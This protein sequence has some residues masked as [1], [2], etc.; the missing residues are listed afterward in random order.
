[1]NRVCAGFVLAALFAAAG[2]PDPPGLPY[3]AGLPAA[4]SRFAASG[5]PAASSRFAAS[6]LPAAAGRPG[7]HE[8]SA[9]TGALTGW[10]DQEIPLWEREPS[11]YLSGYERT[12]L[13]G[14]F[15]YH[16]PHPEVRTSLLTRAT[17]LPMP[18]A[19]ET[20]LVPADF[21]APEAI[22]V[23]LGGFNRGTPNHDFFFS[24]DGRPA[25]TVSTI[26]DG[27]GE[28]WEIAGA[29]GC[30]LGFRS[31]LV[32]RYDD[33]MG[34]LYLAVPRSLLTP[35][36]PLRIDVAGERAGSNDWYMTFEH[37]VAESVQL[38]AEPALV[39]D[40]GG[41]RQ[42]IRV[43]VEHLGPPA[44]AD[45]L[46]D[47]EVIGRLDLALGYNALDTSLPEV[48]EPTGARVEVRI[49]GTE[50][51]ARTVTLSPVAPRTLY[52]LHHSHVDIGYTHVQEE[53]ARLQAGHLENAI[54][55]AEASRDHPPGSRFIWN[56]E[57]LWA[58][59]E[60]LR[61]ATPEQR[62]RLSEAVRRG[63]IGLDALYANVL[64]GLCR[65]EELMQLF[66]T[67]RALGEEFGVTVD[68]AMIT[69]IPGWSWAL[70]PAMAANGVRY[71]SIGPN[72]GH[73]IGSIL[74]D[75]G[76]KP[77]WW[78]S[79]SGEDRVLVWV[80]GRGYSWFHTGLGATAIT[81]RLRPAAVLEYV[82]ELA[83]AQ[84]PFE[85]AAFRYNI[86]SDNGPPDAHLA[87]T[88]RA[89]NERF[90]TP[91]IVIA[92]TAGMLREFERRYGDELP[93]LRGDI[94][95]YWEDGAGSSARETALNRRSAERLT[96]AGA[97]AAILA[98]GLDLRAAF[99]EA[100]RHVLLY[101]EH[102]WGSWNS[103]SEP[104][105]LFTLQQWETKQSFALRADS[106]S[107]A[108][109]DRIV[110]AAGA[111]PRSTPAAA[112]DIINTSSWPRS[113]LVILDQEIRRSG[114][115]VTD[116]AGSALPSQTLA[117]GS[118]AVYL[119]DVPAF[120]SRRLLI[121]DGNP[122]RGGTVRL[123]GT[124]LENGRVRV[125]VDPVSGAVRSL[126]RTG[127]SEEYV[128]N[129]RLPGLNAYYYVAGRD[130]ASPQPAGA[131]TVTVGEEGPLLAS[132]V[133]TSPAPGCRRLRREVR[134]A[135]DADWVE[136]VD[137]LDKERVLDPEG[138]CLAFPF[139]IPS[140]EVRIDLGWGHYRPGTDQLPGAN[141]NYYSV[142]HWV[143]VSNERTGVTL[144]PM[145][146]P[147]LEI[148][149]ITTDAIAVGWLES[150]EPSS[151]LYSYVM[152]NYW[153]TNYRAYQDGPVTLCYAV[154]PHGSFDP[155]ETT[156]F[157][158]DRSQPFVVV[159]TD[160]GAARPGIG[161]R[162]EPADIVATILPPERGVDRLRLRLYN[163]TAAPLRAR[164]T[165]PGGEVKEIEV[166]AL[167]V[168]TVD[169]EQRAG[170]TGG[171]STSR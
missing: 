22:F 10:P 91:R 147:L 88:V 167:A 31:V 36:R 59:D 16:S 94:T 150:S 164:L 38:V 49:P 128:D 155:A 76:D 72:T 139:R 120:G 5:L 107:C 18:I 160:P 44:A 13:G 123:A 98:P 86:G 102:T 32:D 58:V 25:F 96:Q 144:V 105:A 67:A 138:V 2:A 130:P 157:G 108:L 87:D 127:E 80:A 20:A 90:I 46:F 143:D 1:M 42:L 23:W 24:I 8:G 41:P 35:G 50:P 112:V 47:G 152:N 34:Y 97:L 48:H 26:P 141:H 103:I 99:G 15:G 106:L 92:T 3:S 126:R 161:L 85:L 73:R 148:G 121:G 65:P 30:R 60:Y 156:R 29:D 136:I 154:R 89:W 109:V 77:F 75:L 43:D 119:A 28:R 169:T 166:A 74:R 115:R 62:E 52:L 93:V 37:P 39:H 4:S 168:V 113:G 51:L 21:D 132:L 114:N 71:F 146:A 40:P 12:L 142:Q 17:E 133:V 79:P 81:Q 137:T 100:W 111:R 116:E 135:H 70:V 110:T 84:W 145:D 53:V 69:D 27:T 131:V 9:T 170:G 66:A 95:G 129:S 104:E 162:I 45:V 153:E 55:Y 140:G 125:E 82:R 118:L 54:A 61:T 14:G 159:N 63:W 163:P 124:V 56:T 64:T 158:L 101:S 134:L 83:A 11:A 33:L 122:A 151:T 7:A 57:V 165:G 6:G 171:Y 117:D 78:E 19:W 149:A 68:G